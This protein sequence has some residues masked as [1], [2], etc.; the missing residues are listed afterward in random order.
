MAAAGAIVLFDKFFGLSTGWMRFM[1]TRLN[2][3]ETL[4]AFYHDWAILQIR[5]A[6]ERD[7]VQLLEKIK[8]FT[9]RIER[10]VLNETKAWTSEF[11]TSISNIDEMINKGKPDA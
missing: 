2:M 8:D 4:N 5:G 11:K 9:F 1:E 6:E 10:L 7:Y 3:E